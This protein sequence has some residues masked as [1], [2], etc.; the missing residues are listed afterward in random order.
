[1]AMPSY[2][3]RLACSSTRSARPFVHTERCEA[4]FVALSTRALNNSP[5]VEK[6]SSLISGSTRQLGLSHRT[7]KEELDA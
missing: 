3:G 5:R 6:L 1:M 2:N 4:T 7:M